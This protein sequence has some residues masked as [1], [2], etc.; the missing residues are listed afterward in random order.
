[1]RLT[2][3]ATV[4]IILTACTADIV[5]LEQPYGA[6]PDEY[7]NMVKAEFAAKDWAAKTLPELSEALAAG[8]YSSSALT[9]DYLDRIAVTDRSGPRLRAVL[10][11]NPDA[12]AQAK[13]SDARRQS[14]QSLGPLDGIPILLKDNIETLDPIATTAGAIALKDWKR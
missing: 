2:C 11:L 5:P 8:E 6:S 10:S 4:S 7:A 13:A 3:L 14:G 12:M 1:M 9:Q